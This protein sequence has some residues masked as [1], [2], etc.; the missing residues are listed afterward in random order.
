MGEPPVESVCL[1]LA[2]G[3][4]DRFLTALLPVVRPLIS[5]PGFLLW[6]AWL[7]WVSSSAAPLAR[8]HPRS[9]CAGNHAA[10]IDGPLAVSLIKLL[11]GW[12]MVS[13]KAFGGEVHELGVMLLVFTPVP[14]L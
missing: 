1:A 8:P 10:F 3:D 12:D 5:W 14:Y 11:H 4:P 9:D 2:A 7:A 13:T 6:L